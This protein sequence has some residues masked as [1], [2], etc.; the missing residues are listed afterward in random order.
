MN[1]KRQNRATTKQAWLIVAVVLA[2]FAGGFLVRGGGRSAPPVSHSTHDTTG[3]TTRWTCSMHPQI[4]LP[5]N[6]QKCPICA[7]DL[8]PLEQDN[9]AGLA[10]GDLALTETAAALADVATDRVSRRFVT[11]AVRLVGKVSADES[12]TR[13]ITARVGGRLDKLYVDTTGQEVTAGMRLAEIYSPELYTAQAELQAAA[14][15]A[16][17]DSETGALAGSAPATLRAASER[18]R[19]WG[20]SENQIKRITAGDGISEYLTVTAP[21]GGVVIERMATRGDYVQTGSVL[22]AIADLSQV[23]IALEAFESDVS[24]LRPGQAVTFTTRAFPGRDFTGDILFI[25]PVLDERTGTIEVR[26][27][28]DNR[29]GL[30]K[31]GMLVVGRVESALDADGLPVRDQTQAKPPLVVP[32]SAPLLTGERAI[33]YVKRTGE[34]GPVFSGRQVVLGP[35]AGDY[36]LVVSGLSEGE[37]VVTRGN[38][39]IDSALQIQA[40][41]SMMN[42]IGGGSA[43][44]VRTTVGQT[45]AGRFHL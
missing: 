34:D 19:L 17:Q 14:K 33:V 20:M 2:A 32:A 39:K 27:A 31:P 35:R 16:R 43:P 12:K 22:Y 21:V 38:F 23:W 41:P 9:T 25:D 40:Q 1:D 42:P 44:G 29:A 30:L 6:D 4:I 45:V 28:V 26:V 13:S 5:S 10:P 36:Y 3:E 24:W 15:A 7:M 37:E 18:L 11:R 8:I